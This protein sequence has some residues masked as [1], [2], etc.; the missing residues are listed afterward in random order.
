MDKSMNSLYG[1]VYDD[2]VTWFGAGD[3]EACAEQIVEDLEKAGYEKVDYKGIVEY[4]LSVKRAYEDKAAEVADLTTQVE[5]LQNEK[6]NLECTLMETGERLEELG[7]GVDDTIPPPIGSTV[8]LL[9]KD[10]VSV[11]TVLAIGRDGFFAKSAF[12]KNVV[13]E[14]KYWNY[15]DFGKTWFTDFAGVTEFLNVFR[16]RLMEIEKGYFEIVEGKENEQAKRD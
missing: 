8:Y 1:L 12:D 2:I 16:K 7:G 13:D 11:D 9:Y 5:V 3:R 15:A 4:M 14:F 10:S 6:D